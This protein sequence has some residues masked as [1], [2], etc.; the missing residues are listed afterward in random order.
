MIRMRS[1]RIELKL[2]QEQRSLCVRSAGTS[3]YAYNWMLEKLIGEYEANKALATMYGLNK[4]PST[5]G[6]SIDWH[7]E[8]C[9]LKKNDRHKWIYETSK[10]CGQE[11]LR[12]L[13]VAFSKFFKKLNGYPKKKKRGVNDSF[14][15]TGTI[16][17]GYDWVQLPGIGIVKLKEK[18]YA[19]NDKDSKIDLPQATVSRQA[20]HWYVSFLLR[21]EVADVH[22]P[23]LDEITDDEYD[24][25]GV[26]L[27]VKD[28]AITSYGEVFKNP[29][30]YK[31]K[32]QRLKRYQRSV[33][34][35]KKGSKNKRKAVL[36]LSRLHKT[37]ADI[38]NDACHKMT[39]SLVKIKP[40]MIVIESLKPKNMS[41]N[42]KLAS[43]I[44]D[45]AFGKI[46]VQFQYKTEWN[47]VHLVQAPMFYASSKFCSSCGYKNVDL[48]LEDREW[49][50]PCCG[51][52][53]DR[54]VNAALN[55]RFFGLWLMDLLYLENTTVSSTGVACPTG[56]CQ[57]GVLGESS[58][59]HR[60]GRLQF[61]NEQCSS[62]KQE[63]KYANF[64]PAA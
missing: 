19:V 57:S 23:T 58:P 17:I 27:G 20:D 64:A 7:K 45:S 26:D 38:R 35:K 60:D 36:K 5:M 52:H 39:T 56:E 62:L 4:V 43:S 11:A 50:C 42:R 30:A 32:I 9:K 10:C 22:K 29:K 15:L 14:R 34:R 16:R 6:T 1:Y 44:L 46:K 53:H 40:K 33:S 18:G 54:D 63:F 55:L 48:K 21:E 59:M 12:D 61:F 8:W 47:G 24:I 41:K 49:K 13:Q 2:N 25:I 31:Q 51:K 3:R 37:V 28:L